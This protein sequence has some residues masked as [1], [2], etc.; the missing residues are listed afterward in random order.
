MTLHLLLHTSVDTPVS[1]WWA[2]ATGA[3]LVLVVKVAN[4]QVKYYRSLTASNG[5][6]FWRGIAEFLWPK[7]SKRVEGS[8]DSVSWVTTIGIV[9]ML[10]GVVAHNMDL[11]LPEALHDIVEHRALAF[12]LGSM[13]EMIA[14]K[15][16]NTM[17]DNIV[18]VFRIK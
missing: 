9:W 7:T 6:W 4:Y 18:R 15:L 11:L 10:G 3:L 17:V 5:S 8:L 1:H 12:M 2:Y 16:A 14:P 13:A